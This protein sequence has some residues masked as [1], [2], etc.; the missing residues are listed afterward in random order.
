MHDFELALFSTRQMSI[1]L[2]N[3]FTLAR[4]FALAYKLRVAFALVSQPINAKMKITGK[5]ADAS[6]DW[7]D[8]R[9]VIVGMRGRA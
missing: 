9:G 3:S 5:F 4:D 8:V 2:L 1:L 6:V 7:F